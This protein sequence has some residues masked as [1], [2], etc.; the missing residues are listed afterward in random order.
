MYIYLSSVDM[1]SVASLHC[2][3]SIQYTDYRHYCNRS[4]NFC[5]IIASTIDFSLSGS[6]ALVLATQ[7][8]AIYF[9]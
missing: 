7:P 4:M 2:G 6:L 1:K 9:Y 3:L 5:P 8:I